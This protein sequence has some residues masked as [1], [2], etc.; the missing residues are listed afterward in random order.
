MER[1][2]RRPSRGRSKRD[3]TADERLDRLIRE[4]QLARAQRAQSER[5]VVRS[6]RTVGEEV[7]QGQGSSRGSGDQLALTGLSPE[8]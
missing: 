1:L 2:P 7:G 6:V 5:P 3:E 4:E 8:Q